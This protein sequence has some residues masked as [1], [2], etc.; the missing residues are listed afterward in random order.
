MS[1][2]QNL[3]VIWLNENPIAEDSE[4]LIK[5]IEETCP[6]VE[7]LNSKF[8]KNITH[9]GVKFGHL[10]PRLDRFDTFDLSKATHLNLSSRN[11]F[12]LENF[13]L[14][15]QLPALTSIDV[16]KHEIDDFIHMNKLIALMKAIPKLKNIDCD[17]SVADILWDL[18]KNKKLKDI[19]P[20]LVSINTYLLSQSK[21][22][23]DE[24]D[25]MFIMNNIWKICGTYRLASS[26]QL[27]ESNVWYVMDEFGSAIQH[28]FDP[29]CITPPFLY[30]PSK[31]IDQT[32]I[33]YSILLPI[34]D[35]AAGEELT[36]NYIHGETDET[37]KL[38]RSTVWFNVPEKFFVDAYLE[39]KV[40]WRFKIILSE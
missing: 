29:N 31:K 4:K 14:F 39:Q 30:V 38:A 11:V 12:N 33:S 16:K 21:P 25:I 13:D 19:A 20:N 6:K 24:E 17:A 8:T 5:I 22:R 27:D 2:F 40:Y 7:I 34:K 32:S 36:R 1:G 37:L 3:K 9:W 35:I 18:H 10:Y 28:D 15:T 23:A 26:E